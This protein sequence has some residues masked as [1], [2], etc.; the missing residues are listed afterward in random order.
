MSQ[1]RVPVLARAALLY[2]ISVAAGG[3][4]S[5]AAMRLLGSLL[6]AQADPL[7]Y[8]AAGLVLAAGASCVAPSRRALRIDPAVA[9]RSE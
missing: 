4:L 8:V 6:Y 7:V 1:D 5:L 9:L 3:L 2:G